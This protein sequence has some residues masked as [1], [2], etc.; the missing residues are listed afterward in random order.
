MHFAHTRIKLT[1]AIRHVSGVL[2]SVFTVFPV[3]SGFSGLLRWFCYFTFLGGNLQWYK[4]NNSS[5]VVRWRFRHFPVSPVLPDLEKGQ[6]GRLHIIQLHFR[7]LVFWGEVI[8]IIHPNV[9]EEIIK[10]PD[11]RGI[12]ERETAEDGIKGYESILIGG[13]TMLSF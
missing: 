1:V 5:W 7:K 9:G 4:Q 12:A 8:R 13:M 11:T 10:R 3:F 6:C 2:A